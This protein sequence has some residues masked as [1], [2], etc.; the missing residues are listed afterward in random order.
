MSIES[1]SDEELL[2]AARV[3]GVEPPEETT[4][5]E[6]LAQFGRGALGDFA[7]RGRAAVGA[8]LEELTPGMADQATWRERYDTYKEDADREEEEFA[9]ADPN[10]KKWLDRAGLAASVVGGGGLAGKTAAGLTRATRAALGR[11]AAKA[12]GRAAGA[13]KPH[14]TAAQVAAGQGGR[15]AGGLSRAAARA[16]STASGPGANAAIG[17]AVGALDEDATAVQGAVEGVIFGGIAGKI[18]GSEKLQALKN[19]AV[20]TPIGRMGISQLAQRLG[21]SSPKAAALWYAMHP[22]SRRGLERTVAA[23]AGKED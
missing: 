5:M 1:V 2:R 18:L 4:G 13:A 7:D 11:G 19:L 3:L 12:G 20:N 15:G 8:T 21:I 6:K 17:G 10:A 22:V 23:Y 16:K 9:L 14:Y